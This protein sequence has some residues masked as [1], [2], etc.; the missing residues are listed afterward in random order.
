MI[1]LSTKYWDG[2]IMQTIIWCEVV[3]D[4]S[5]TQLSKHVNFNNYN[6]NY[7]KFHTSFSKSWVPVNIFSA[8]E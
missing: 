4:V 3:T 8:Y 5:C 6:Q 1:I 2:Q 7:F